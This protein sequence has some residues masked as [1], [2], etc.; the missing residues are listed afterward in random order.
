MAGSRRYRLLCPIARALDRVGDRWTLLILRDLHAGPARFSD[1]QSG[2]KGIASNLLT[3]RLQQLTDDGLIEKRETDLGVAVYALT[4]L[5]RK[6][7]N[8]LFELA[9]FG[10]RFAPDE[11]LTKP[12]NLR[13]I[14]VTMA[15]A[16]ERIVSPDMNF[17]AGFTVDGEPFTLTVTD[18]KVDMRSGRPES[19]DVDVQTSYEPM[20]AAAEGEIGLAEFV[21]TQ[22]EFVLHTSGK[23]TEVMA[24]LTGV[25]SLLQKED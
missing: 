25:M 4:D 19:P 13:T 14:A 6:T 21:K 8:I 12:G 1:L 11:I 3:E 7:R 15:A 20:V 17:I 22:L 24:F 5:G 10:G 9:L 23:E 16:G 18:G 2:L